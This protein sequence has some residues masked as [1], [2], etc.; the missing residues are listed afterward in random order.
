MTDVAA[1][2]ELALACL[3]ERLP[4][5]WRHVQAVANHAARLAAVMDVDATTLVC[6]A[7]LHDIGYA[8]SVAVTGFHP[9]DGARFLR[10]AGWPDAV[11][12]LVAHHS[13]ADVEAAARGFG[14][15]LGGEFRDEPSVERDALWTADAT[16]GPDGQPMSLT[17]RVREVEGRHGVNHLV[18]QCMR[19]IRPELTAAITRTYSRLALPSSA[20]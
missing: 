9:L 2:A 10:R 14:D 16:R 13:C 6:A 11:C 3:A 8:P 12:M 15:E 7:W 1:A 20:Q 17:E 19:Q 4:R 5:R 18:S